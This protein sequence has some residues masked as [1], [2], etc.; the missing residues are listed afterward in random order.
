MDV[1]VLLNDTIDFERVDV[2]THL[3][4]YLQNIFETLEYKG[5]N[6]KEKGWKWRFGRGAKKRK[7]MPLGECWG[8]DKK[9]IIMWV[10]CLDD[11][12]T[13]FDEIKDTFVHEM[14]HAFDNEIRGKSDHSKKWKEICIEI[15]CTPT[16]TCTVALPAKMYKF[17]AICTTCGDVVYKGKSR[18]YDKNGQKTIHQPCLDSLMESGMSKNDALDQLD[19]NWI[20]NF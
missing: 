9:E 18:I 13:T 8:G 11:E 16:A 3:T 17:N 14:A 12:C 15:G 4:E 5:I 6:L 10:W 20:K 2:R 1:E 19:V 7:N